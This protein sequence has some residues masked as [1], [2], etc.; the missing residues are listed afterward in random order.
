MCVC[1]LGS[2]RA[3]LQG[4]SRP[5]HLPGSDAAHEPRSRA[6]DFRG[7]A[8]FTKLLLLWVTKAQKG[9]R[10]WYFFPFIVTFNAGAEGG[11]RGWGLNKA[12]LLKSITSEPVNPAHSNIGKIYR[13]KSQQK[14]HKYDQCVAS[15]CKFII[16]I[17]LN[18]AQTTRIVWNRM[19]A[20]CSYY[21]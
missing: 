10:G 21:Y 7:F 11:R 1:S 8:C 14:A 3:E 12:K 9:G 19:V 17:P 15:I 4:S 13:S 16:N 2:T 5:L 6:G 20:R 18:C